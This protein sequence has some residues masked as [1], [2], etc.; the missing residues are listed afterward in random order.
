M[1][2]L[3]KVPAIDIVTVCTISILLGYKTCFTYGLIC[4]YALSCLDQIVWRLQYI[5][6]QQHSKRNKE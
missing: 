2:V 4:W 1:K 6:E 3:V 5:I